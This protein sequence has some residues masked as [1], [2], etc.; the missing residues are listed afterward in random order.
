VH[1]TVIGRRGEGVLRVPQAI[2]VGPQGQ[3]YEGDQYSYVVQRFS[4]TGRFLGQWG[5]YGHGSGQLGAIG[6]LAVDHAGDV[7]VVDS[8]NSRVE[9]FDPS[10]RFLRG[11]GT[12]GR[13]AG[14][15]RF[16]GGTSPQDPPGG[17]IAVDATHVYVSDTANSRIQRFTLDGAQPTV[18]GGPGSGNGGFSNPRG[19]SV[20]ASALYVADN[21]NRRVVMLALDG[22]FR[23]A[24]GSFGHGPGQFADPYDVAVDAR[25][26]DVFVAD[27]NN[28]RIVRLSSE[29]SWQDTWDSYSGGPIS[30]IRGV[31]TDRDGRLYVA[32]AALDR[33]I[34]FD[35]S[36]STLAS[37]GI[38]G[39]G[40][41]DFIAPQA[42]AL[43]RSGGFMVVEGYGSRSRLYLLDSTLAYRTRWIGGRGV[44]LGTHH[45]F[46]PTAA[47]MALDGTVW[48]ADRANDVIRHL[49][50]RGGFLGA[51]GGS[52]SNAPGQFVAPTGVAVGPGGDVFV[53]DTGNNRLQQF[54]ASG[55]FVRVFGQGVG[56]H[57]PGAIALDGRGTVYVV[58]SDDRIVELDA[59]GRRL[60]AWGSHGVGAGQ[61]VRPDGI[62][63]D[64]RGD[65]FVSDGGNDRV[66][67]FAPTR[68]FLASWGSSGTGPGQFRGPGGLAISCRGDLVVTDTFNNRVQVFA[69]VAAVPGCPPSARHRASPAQG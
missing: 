33:V 69:G 5:S 12:R 10:G 50:S 25:S 61:F 51:L 7:Y 66:Q 65:V 1:V 4:S 37:W 3:I 9:K 29:L 67:E 34:A 40:T 13:A 49:D 16:G 62:A 8:T 23:K 60:A 11:W 14:Q 38:S 43:D 47:A 21:D 30:F 45:F 22:R 64:A 57:R 26:G 41:R 68:R 44:I 24:I 46:G 59:S 27:D 31:A 42:L 55:R 54:T 15:F 18:W 2:A 52:V 63:I 53:S 56:L 32:D 20:T 6:A 39:N 35:R 28:N 36:G 17:G 58:N 48:V 19:L